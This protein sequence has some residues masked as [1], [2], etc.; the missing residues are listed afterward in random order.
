M[1][2][3]IPWC[4]AWR[5]RARHRRAEDRRARGRRAATRDHT[6]SQCFGL[7]PRFER[8]VTQEL[9][10]P[11]SAK[12]RFTMAH[13]RSDTLV[14]RLAWPCSAPPCSAPPCCNPRSHPSARPRLS[15][16]VAPAFLRASIT[17][18]AVAPPFFRWSITHRA[19][20]SLDS[21]WPKEDRIPWCGAWR[22][23]A[24]HRRAASRERIEYGLAPLS[25]FRASQSR[26]SKP[27][28]RWP[29]L[30][31]YLGAAVLGVAVLGTAVGERVGVDVVG[32]AVGESVQSV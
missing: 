9:H 21:R 12:P 23:R 10:T 16:W 13:A 19:V 2:D 8:S 1:R 17:H 31:R 30:M 24:R 29:S 14:R 7:N 20:A 6:L 28:S 18:R 25:S 5:G 11:C 22:G 32:V 15:L 4:G 27:M 26:N 3:R